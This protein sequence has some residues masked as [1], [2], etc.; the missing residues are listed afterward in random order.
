MHLIRS[1]AVFIVIA[2]FVLLTQAFGSEK[3]LLFHAGLGQRSALNEIKAVFEKKYPEIKVN[4]S[5]TSHFALLKK[6]FSDFWFWGFFAP[7]R[8]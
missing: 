2:S 6:L 1:A 7:V 3:E 8:V 5:Y 4:F